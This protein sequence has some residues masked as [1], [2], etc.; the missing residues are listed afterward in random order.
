MS[1]NGRP[2]KESAWHIVPRKI[3][4][5]FWQVIY[6]FHRQVRLT[7]NHAKPDFLAEGNLWNCDPEILHSVKKR[8]GM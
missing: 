4:H 5:F 8:F 7:G 6:V 2:L 3:T 1:F